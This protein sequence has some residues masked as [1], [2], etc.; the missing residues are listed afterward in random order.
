[1]NRRRLLRRIL[2]GARNVRFSDFVKLIEAFGFRLSRTSGSHDIFVP[3]G[4]SELVNL[5]EVDGQV[6]T[7]QIQQ[8]LRLVERY[9]LRMEDES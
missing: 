9:N 6:K 5:Q 8:W 4:I 2:G 7:Y 3:A 1:M